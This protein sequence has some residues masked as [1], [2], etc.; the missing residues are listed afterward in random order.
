V[1]REVKYRKLDLDGDYTFGRRNE[2]CTDVEAVAQAV[3]TRL[4]LLKGEWWENTIDGTPFFE[5]VAGQFFS[6]I[7]DASQV[8]LVFSERITGT[9]GVT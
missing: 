5:E 8:D 3:R 7:E 2:F 1:V 4:L 9:Q 6:S